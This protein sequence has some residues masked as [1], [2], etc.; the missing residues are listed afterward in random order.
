MKKPSAATRVVAI[1]MTSLMFSTATVAQDISGGAGVLQANA[2]VEAKLGKGIFT[3]AKNRQHAAKPLEKKTVSRSAHTT[4]QTTTGNRQTG[5]RTPA[6][7]GG[8]GSNP[9]RA[10]DAEDYNQKGDEFFDA[11]QYDKAAESYQQAIRLRPDYAEAHLNLGETHFNRG[12]YDEAIASDKQAIA[13]KANWPE[14]YRA[15]GTAYL[16][17]DKSAE[18][19][20]AL[21]KAYELNSKD[22][23]TRASL[24]L[25]YFDQGVSAYN[26]DK[27]VEA[28]SL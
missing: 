21:E 5:G 25:A 12:R 18:A 9:T 16:K 2:E 28:V 4:R 24:S 14:A 7:T 27:F 8:G 20:E 13:L 22:A 23:E 17:A 19:R 6:N 26:S 11:G 1:A 10:L 3:P 15:L